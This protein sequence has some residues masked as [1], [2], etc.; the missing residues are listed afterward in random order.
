MVASVAVECGSVGDITATDLQTMLEQIHQEA[1]AAIVSADEKASS[2]Q[3][4]IE[5]L[6]TELDQVYAAL[7]L[8]RTL[9]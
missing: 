7:G 6:N 5:K 1:F 2:A 8:T 4:L 9:T 3:Q